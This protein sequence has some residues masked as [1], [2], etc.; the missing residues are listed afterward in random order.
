MFSMAVEIIMT[1]IFLRKAIA[2]CENARCYN[3]LCL[4]ALQT[5]ESI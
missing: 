5:T 1:R 4:Q 2:C 3:I